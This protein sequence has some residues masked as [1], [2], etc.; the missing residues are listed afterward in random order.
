MT[1]DG[2][3]RNPARRTLDLC[4]D[5][6]EQRIIRAYVGLGFAP[7][8]H[9]RRITTVGWLGPREVRLAEAAPNAADAGM[10]PIW[11]EVYCHHRGTV[12]DACGCFDFDDSELEA[13]V[14]LVMKA[15]R[16][17]RHCIH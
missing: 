14:D 9:G 5:L 16:N 1:Y 17:V 7:H 4:P 3:D 12:L 8:I 6:I 15:G 11:V 10:P 2:S 13:A